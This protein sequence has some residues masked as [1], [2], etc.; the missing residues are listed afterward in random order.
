AGRRAPQGR[1]A[2][3]ARRVPLAR[4]V[5]RAAHRAQP[6]AAAPGQRAG[7]SRARRARAHA[8]R[9]AADIRELEEL[10]QRP[11]P[12]PSGAARG[13]PCGPSARFELSPPRTRGEAM[14]RRA[15]QMRPRA[16]ALGTLLFVLCSCEKREPSEESA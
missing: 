1:A 16:L 5:R 13:A 7:G 11:D 4:A 15:V 2:D 12:R 10:A 9:R 8:V 6:G 3:L 14:N